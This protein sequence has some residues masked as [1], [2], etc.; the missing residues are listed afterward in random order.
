[1]VDAE[2]KWILDESFQWVTKL[3]A[4]KEKHIWDLSKNLYWYDYLTADEMDQI[5]KGKT[6]KKDKVR[7]WEGE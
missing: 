3:M 5:I 2:V 7:N 4:D 6:L 1:M